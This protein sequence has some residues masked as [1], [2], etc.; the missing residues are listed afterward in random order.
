MEE[1]KLEI[2]TNLEAE[3]AYLGAILNRPE[4][5]AGCMLEPKHFFDWKNRDTFEVMQNL[6][7]SNRPPNYYVVGEAL[8]NKKAFED[9][10]VRLD[11]LRGKYYF[12]KPVEQL[13][14]LILEAYRKRTAINELQEEMA[15]LFKPDEYTD[16]IFG[17]MVAKITKISDP[18]LSETYSLDEMMALIEIRAA[19]PTKIYGLETGLRDFD[20]QTHGLQ[21]KEVFIL[22]GEPGSGKSL[23]AGQLALGMAEHGASGAFYSLEMSA[24]ALYMRWLSAK[25]GINTSRMKEGWDMTGELGKV[26]EW[27]EKLKSTPI[28]V[29]EQAMWTP[30][31][32]RADIAG[33]K[34][35]NNIDFIVIDYLDLL[36]DPSAND[37]NE[38]SE[39]LI[40]HLSNLAKEFDIAILTIQSLVKSGFGGNPALNDIS[41][42]HKVSYTVDS[43]A[44]LVG[45]PDEKIKEL[46]WIKTRH[47]DDT[48]NLK[49]MLKRGL[50]EF[51]TVSE[52][53]DDMIG[54][55]T[56]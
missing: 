11:Y 31:K 35:K 50:P 14:F 37:K 33:L 48:K 39:N 22:L 1:V 8:Q 54:D 27:V 26:G 28:I 5:L 15:R 24:E 32:L 9:V 36:L 47:S 45:K 41:G 16:R 21:K 51:A 3:E 53:E 19:N 42:S 25:T 44:A 30:I 6:L 2:P 20:L 49:L 52:R 43:A 10:F 56:R 7:D 38:K 4:E 12:Q 55:Y 46:R 34:M 17:D 18:L 23:L 29:R 13:E 40:I